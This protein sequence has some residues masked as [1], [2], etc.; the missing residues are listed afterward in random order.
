MDDNTTPPRE[1]TPLRPRNTGSGSGTDPREELREQLEAMGRAASDLLEHLV[2]VPAT[3][4]QIPLQALPEDTATHARNAATEGMRAVRT[5]VEGISRGVDQMMRE[6]ADRMK[7]QQG[8]AES[9]QATDVSS[10]AGAPPSDTAG[11]ADS[12]TTRLGGEDTDLPGE[13]ST[14]D[15][16]A[17]TVRLHD[18]P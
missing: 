4:A 7:A 6:Q 8:S 5:L 14:G 18:E 16:P 12:L 17:H 3:L 11:A 2:K 1:P 10:A 15:G 9:Y 13:H